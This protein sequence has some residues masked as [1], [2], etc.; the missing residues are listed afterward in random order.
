LV[1]IAELAGGTSPTP[2]PAWNVS[3][4]KFLSACERRAVRMRHIKE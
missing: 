1:A 2:Q 4:S 3:A